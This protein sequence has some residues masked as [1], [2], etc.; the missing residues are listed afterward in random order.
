MATPEELREFFARSDWLDH[1]VLRPLSHITLNWEATW[2]HGAMRYATEADSF[3]DDLNA[4]I[5]LI[6]AA[7]RPS[8]YHDNED[9]LAERVLRDMKWPI[10]KKVAAG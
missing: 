2:D 9:R 4:V 7:T 3:A 10:Q 6:A 1:A 5:E 8:R